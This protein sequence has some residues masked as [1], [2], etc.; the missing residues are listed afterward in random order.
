MNNS[1]QEYKGFSHR[2]FA[3][4]MLSKDRTSEKA[5]HTYCKSN[6][7]ETFKFGIDG[8]EAYKPYHIDTT[9]RAAPDKICLLPSGGYL[10][11]ELKGCGNRGLYIKCSS[12]ANYLEWNKLFIVFAF[13]YN[14]ATKM[15]SYMPMIEL[16]AIADNAGKTI[17]ENMGEVFHIPC[18]MIEWTNLPIIH[19][20]QYA[21]NYRN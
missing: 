8:T 7:I 14:S 2:P 6:N 10:L 4:R 15:Y 21:D 20:P 18:A 17:H 11:T 12:L 9:L 19:E 5:F 3:E 16:A 13:I 1:N